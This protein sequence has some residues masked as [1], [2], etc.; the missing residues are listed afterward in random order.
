MR[1]VRQSRVTGE[2]EIPHWLGGTD[3]VLLYDGAEAVPVVVRGQMNDITTYPGKDG[4]VWCTYLCC[5]PAAPYPPVYRER[6]VRAEDWATYE[7]EECGLRRTRN[8]RHRVFADESMVVDEAD[9]W[10]YVRYAYA[11]NIEGREGE[12]L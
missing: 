1:A 2:R 11:R 5:G 6:V 9:I 10:A 12:L 3:Y 8:W 7:I 4:Q